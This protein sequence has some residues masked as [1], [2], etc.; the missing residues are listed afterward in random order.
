MSWCYSC[1]EVKGAGRRPRRQDK[2]SGRERQTRF[3][4]ITTGEVVL[5][6]VGWWCVVRVAATKYP[7]KG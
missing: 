1:G 6:L 7:C 2:T 4:A 5:S 3:I